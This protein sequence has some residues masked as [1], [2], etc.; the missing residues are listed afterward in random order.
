MRVRSPQ[1]P[2]FSPLHAQVMQRQTYLF[3]EQGFAGSNPALR[4]IRQAET[5]RRPDRHPL[6]TERDPFP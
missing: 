3:Q 2:Y 4:T 6:R 1:G 5:C